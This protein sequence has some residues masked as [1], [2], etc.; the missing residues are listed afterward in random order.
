MET[1]LEVTGRIPVPLCGGLLGE[2]RVGA[3]RAQREL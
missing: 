1:A 2:G 3:L